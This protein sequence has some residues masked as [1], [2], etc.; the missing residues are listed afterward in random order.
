MQLETIPPGLCQ[1]GCG[2]KTRIIDSNCA[3][4]GLVKGQPRKFCRGHH[5]RK[6]VRWIETEGPLSTPC[7]ISTMA[8]KPDGYADVSQAGRTR[9]AHIVEWEAANGPVPED[10]ELDHLCRVRN[11]VNPAHLEAVTAQVN[12]LRGFS[13]AAFNAMK[14]H[15]Q[16]GH[17][18]TPENT[19]LVPTGRKCRACSVK[20]QHEW[21]LA[22]RK[23]R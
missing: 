8:A 21:Y 22:N 4:R 17:E 5:S 23:A 1:C 16:H 7:W 13:P 11:C 20:Y 10:L 2:R 3:S 19:A 15:C 14:T 18:F 6:R 9:R 12:V